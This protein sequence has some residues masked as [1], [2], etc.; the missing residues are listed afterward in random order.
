MF[1][2]FIGFDPRETIAYHVCAHSILKRA[3]IP[4]SITPLRRETLPM[5][6]RPRGPFDSTEFS[7]SRFLVPS[8]CD[9]RGVAL[10]I[11]CDM[12][13]LSDVAELYNIALANQILGDYDVQVVQH[14]YTPISAR[15]FLNQ[16]QTQYSRK[17]WSSVMLFNNE[18]CRALHP[19]YVNEAAGLDLHGFAWTEL[20]GRL[21]PAWNN[22]IGEECELPLK[23]SKLL[24]WTL[25]GPYFEETADCPHADIWNAEFDDMLRAG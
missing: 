14:S 5:F 24:H 8:L 13:V 12:L 19:S 7:I 10:F 18:K 3:S 23:D 17:N 2:I 20:I 22:L 11:D 6:T 1:P 15:K 16:P 9:Y 25:G 4:V 21:S